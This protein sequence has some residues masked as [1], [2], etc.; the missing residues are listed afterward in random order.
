MRGRA[1]TVTGA[2]CGVGTNARGQKQRVVQHVLCLAL[3]TSLT[4]C[5]TQLLQQLQNWRDSIHEINWQLL[6]HLAAGAYL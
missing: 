3:P 5:C 6:L 2:G 4:A 1:E